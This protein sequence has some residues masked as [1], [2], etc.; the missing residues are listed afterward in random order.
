MTVPS[1]AG[2]VGAAYPPSGERGFHLGSYH[3]DFSPFFIGSAMPQAASQLA[4]TATGSMQRLVFAICLVSLCVGGC[5]SRPKDFP[6]L[7]PVTGTVTLDGQPL[8]K[9][10]VMFLSEKGVAAS[11]ATDANGRYTL[12]Y[13][14]SADG[15]S[16]GRNTV[17]VTTLPDDPNMG[18]VKER[19][20]AAYNTKST[21][22]ADVVAGT[23]TFDFALESKP[24]GK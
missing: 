1:I 5:S 23:N 9:A 8:Q 3:S 20:P 16:P 21:L 19:I 10:V 4:I 12:L 17:T 11:G 18:V 15:A 6:A 14:G 13:R 24:S 2:Q 7:A 22:T